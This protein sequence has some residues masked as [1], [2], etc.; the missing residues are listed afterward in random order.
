M[1]V[2][3]GPRPEQ[4]VERYR[5]ALIFFGIALAAGVACVIAVLLTGHYAAVG[6]GAILFAALS[7]RRSDLTVTLMVLISG[8]VFISLYHFLYWQLHVCEVMVP[9]LVIVIW[10][11]RLAV[12]GRRIVWD[13]IFWVMVALIGLAL[14]SWAHSYLFWSRGVPIFHRKILT[15]ISR[16]GLIALAAVLPMVIANTIQDWKQLRRLYRALAW[17]A[18]AAALIAV[19]HFVASPDRSNWPFSEKIP[20]PTVGAILLPLVLAQ[21]LAGEDTRSRRLG[22]VTL[23]IILIAMVLRLKQTTYI[24]VT[25]GGLLM[26]YMARRRLFWGILGTMAV[27]GATLGRTILRVLAIVAE[28]AG[29]LQRPEVWTNCLAIFKDNWL[30]GVGPANLYQHYLARWPQTPPGLAS[31]AHDEYL[32]IGC[33]IGIFGLIVVGIIVG[34]TMVNA[35]RLF[36]H[37]DNG[38]CRVFALGVL[39]CFVAMLFNVIFNNWLLMVNLVD[40]SHTMYYWVLIGMVWVARRLDEQDRTAAGLSIPTAAEHEGSGSPSP[41]TAG[42]RRPRSH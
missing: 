5:E 7:F 31:N 1:S 26:T 36:K 42:A 39:G 4:A 30:F 20:M 10:I 21:A 33:E 24:S 9:I 41:Q 18:L 8:I 3:R 19:G 25:A 27:L 28:R 17:A 6:A 15:Q 38:F 11:Q 14:F 29:S 12:P 35:W 40:F 32:Q 37:T 23:F 2:Y 34:W 22:G 13:R 16:V